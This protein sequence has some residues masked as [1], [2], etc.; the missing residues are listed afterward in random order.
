[1]FVHADRAMICDRCAPGHLVVEYVVRSWPVDPRCGAQSFEAIGST[2]DA[3]RA[4]SKRS[5]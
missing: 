5:N 2:P 4:L 3:S 1:M